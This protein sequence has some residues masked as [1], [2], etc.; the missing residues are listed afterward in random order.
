MK[1][2]ILLALLIIFLSGCSKENLVE[3]MFKAGEKTL[4][5]NVEETNPEVCGNLTEVAKKDT[6]YN[7]VAVNTLNSKICDKIE[8][9]RQKNICLDGVKTKNGAV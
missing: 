9:E 7:V 3:N 1:K 5:F 4:G 2:L 8:S 6:C